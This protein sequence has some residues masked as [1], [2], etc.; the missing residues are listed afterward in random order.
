MSLDFPEPVTYSFIVWFDGSDAAPGL[1][2]A[3]RA[4][5]FLER[6]QQTLTGFTEYAGFAKRLPQ[7]KPDTVFARQGDQ[8][9]RL[10][11]PEPD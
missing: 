7:Q 2:I 4:D 10:V 3:R 9:C 6:L 8:W 11:F 1:L 5:T